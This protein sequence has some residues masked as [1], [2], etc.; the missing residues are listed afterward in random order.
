MGFGLG[1]IASF[2]AGGP[3]GYGIYKA[4]SGGGTNDVTQ[5]PLRTPE[6]EEAQKALL[7]FSKTGVNGNYKAGEAYTGSLGDFATS[8]LEKAAQAKVAARLG[9]AGT[10][11][12]LAASDQ[13][14]NDL[15][16]TD[17]YNPLNQGGVYDAVS[18]SI[19]RATREATGA[20]KRGA[21]FAG[22]L[23]STDTVQKLGDVQAKGVETKATTLANLYQNYVQQ[24]L[25]GVG[26]AYSNAGAVDS[27]ERGAISDAFSAGSLDR[28]LNT[29]KDQSA[30]LEFQRQR[31]EQQGQI[32]ALTSVANKNTPYGV[33]SVSVPKDNPWL[34]V[35]DLLAQ[36]GGKAIGG[37]VGAA[38]A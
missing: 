1:D 38:S 19:D 21:A 8:A 3:L 20:A 17:K 14:L 29:A 32:G 7:E 31:G 11:T 24:K 23:Y 26:Q 27:M 6:E 5:V 2:A 36:F 10:G 34:T 4:A 33:P 35:M 22:N 12:N 25:G 13:V 16:T 18:G 15:L 30:Y 28:N 9:T 37:K